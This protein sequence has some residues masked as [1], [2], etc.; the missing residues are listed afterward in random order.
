MACTVNKVL[1]EDGSSSQLF[2]ALASVMGDSLAL[3]TYLELK[4]NKDKYSKIYELNAQGEINAQNYLKT[5][6][7]KLANFDSYRQQSDVMDMLTQQFLAALKTEAQT[8][9]KSTLTGINLE[10][11]AKDISLVPRIVDQ[12]K[13]SIQDAV[14]NNPDIPAKQKTLLLSAAENFE[15]YITNREYYTDESGKDRA[16]D[17]LGPVGDRLYKHGIHIKTS[18][19]SNIDEQMEERLADSEEFDNVDTEQ[20]TVDRVRIYD[21]TI[22][23]TPPAS[24][25]LEQLK[26]YL[27]GV[28][29]VSKDYVYSEANPV[30]TFELSE[31][32]QYRGA[33]ADILYSNLSGALKGIQSVEEIGNRLK[34]AIRTN[35]QLVPIYNDLINEQAITIPR[36]G[37][38][39]PLEVALFSLAKQDYNM[40]SVVEMP[41]G[42]VVLM[43]SNSSSVRK[44]IAQ[45][46]EYNIA[47]VKKGDTTAIQERITKLLKSKPL[48]MNLN[49]KT[50]NKGVAVYTPNKS[51]L[52][53]VARAFTLAG[54]EGVTAE[55]LDT[56]IKE[57]LV[58]KELIT[59][60]VESLTPYSIITTMLR[61]LPRKAL[62]SQ[63]DIFSKKWEKGEGRSIK[64]LSEIVGQNKSDIVVGA[65]LSGKGTMTYP[66]NYGSA[67][68]DTMTLLSSQSDKGQEYLNQF[69]N[70]PMYANT[71]LMSIFSKADGGKDLANFEFRTMDTLTNSATNNG[72][73]YGDLSTF[74]ALITRMNAF[75]G[76]T[77]KEGYFQAFTPTQADRG[78]VMTMTVPTY[79]SGKN[80]KVFTKETIADEGIREWLVNQT[81]AELTRAATYVNHAKIDTY[82]DRAKEFTLFPELNGIMNMEQMQLKD[83]DRMTAEIMPRAEKA[84]FDAVQEDIQ[85]YLDNDVLIKKSE[86]L[87]KL[88]PDFKNRFGSKV[89]KLK[90]ISKAD[91]EMFLANN[92]I[93]TYESMLFLSGDP[94][95]Y[96]NNIKLNKR[97]ALPFTPGGKL[98]IGDA[99]GMKQS[100]QVKILKEAKA[101]SEFAELYAA[102]TGNKK[103]FNNTDIADGW[104]I[105]SIDR[106][107]R[108][109]L[110]RGTHT[111]AGLE[112]L[113]QL[114]SWKDGDIIEDENPIGSKKMFYFKVQQLP[115][116][117]MAPLSQKYSL[118]PA[119]PSLFEQK[120]NGEFKYPTLAEISRELRSGRADEIVMESAFK[121]GIHNVSTVDDLITSEPIS[122]END[123]VREV[124]IV[125]NKEKVEDILGSQMRKLVI[126]NFVD[127]GTLNLNGQTL[128]A[129]DALM[130]YNRALASTVSLSS[131]EVDRMLMPGGKVNY[132]NLARELINSA[133]NSSHQNTAYYTN[134][135]SEFVEGDGSMLP[136]NYPT[137]GFR[138]DNF[139][140]SSYRKSV[141][142]IKM[143]GHSA[144]QISSFGT[145]YSKKNE[146]LQ[147]GSNLKF[148]RFAKNGK[149]LKGQD[150]LDLAKKVRKF[151]KT[152]DP[153]LAEELS[154]YTTMPAEVRV[155]PAFFLKTIKNLAIQ[156]TLNNKTL[157]K[158]AREFSTKYGKSEASKKALYNSKR[159]ILIP[160]YEAA[161]YSK[162]LSII[163]HSDGTYNMDK[164]SELGLD[165]IVL[166]RIPTQGKNSMLLAKIKEFLPES[167]GNTIQ[168]P[169]EI[170]D[171]SGSDFDIDKVFIE[172]P[173]FKSSKDSATL[174]RHTYDTA[175]DQFSKDEAQSA[176]FD[177]HKS[178]L[179]SPKHTGE[180]L[181]PN[182]T[183]RLAEV[184][185]ALGI[186]EANQTGN[187]ASIKLQETFRSNNQQGKNLISIS[188]ISSVMHAVAQH[189]KPKFIAQYDIAGQTLE[190][191]RTHNIAGTELISTEIA[192]IQNAAVDNAREPLL[193]LLNINSF[194]AS[195]ALLLVSAGHG[196]KFASAVL[197]APVVKDLSKAYQKYER[198]MNQQDAYDA[199]Y[200]EIIK[201][202]K[203]PRNLGSKLYNMNSFTETTAVSLLG[204]TRELTL[205]D[206]AMSLQAFHGFKL[207]GDQLQK[208]QRIMNSDSKG[209]PAS[210]AKLFTLYTDL[211][212]IPGTKAYANEIAGGES[213][214]TNYNREIN[215]SPI[216]VDKEA[217]N[218]SYLSAMEE[219]AIGAALKANIAISP[220]AS[221]QFQNVLSKAIEK[222]GYLSENAQISI[223]S[224]Y[225]TYL[226]TNSTSNNKA[227][228]GISEAME[229]GE[230]N[231]LT[232]TSHPESTARILDMFKQAVKAGELESNDFI[233]QL[234]VIEDKGRSYVTFL[235]STARA[236][237]GDVKA[238]MMHYYEDLM[239]GTDLE[240]RL[241]K[242]LADYAIVHYG[243]STSINSFM[244]FIPPSAHRTYMNANEGM[245]IPG[246]FENL[247]QEY[248][249]TETFDNDADK[250]LD[251]YIANNSTKLG[252]KSFQSV[253]DFYEDVYQKEVTRKPLLPYVRIY[254]ANIKDYTLYASD[255]N[256]QLTEIPLRGVKNLVMEYHNGPSF[257]NDTEDLG[258]LDSTAEKGNAS[259]VNQKVMDN[260]DW[261]I[262]A[263]NDAIG[264]DLLLDKFTFKDAAAVEPYLV[265]LEKRLT[266]DKR[267]DPLEV[268][269]TMGVFI[270]A[271]SIA[272]RLH[273]LSQTR[274]SNQTYDSI[275]K[276]FI[277][278]GIDEHLEGLYS[279]IIR[280]TC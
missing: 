146:T 92:L 214:L 110:A 44:K 274:K 105:G 13:E 104:G 198:V 72:V 36:V 159:D 164:L 245:S 109:N 237:P 271:K 212:G 22:L 241:A 263:F 79:A 107:R 35:P 145:M 183:E 29:K 37:K 91:M 117:L 28:R 220:A 144:V 59:K 218:T 200:D 39:K 1:L 27:Q 190:L 238:D 195:S 113:S 275:F 240:Q 226:A 119:I 32:G 244:E 115:S 259:G 122:L 262:E 49:K 73:G 76:S 191:G 186:S 21:M 236:V 206:H 215:A 232:Q 106:F 267:I 180:L 87:Y 242:S 225:N 16:R 20:K 251:L 90:T 222:I 249:N 47:T 250:F 255:F 126:G 132:S 150:A 82:S 158:E 196:L 177:F 19:M 84:F 97:L 123:F 65:Y 154:E 141:N 182:G 148:V 217:Y 143:P 136:I 234:N 125:P 56:V 38:Y 165:E 88:N 71:R 74:D 53:E 55:A 253:E 202:Y 18:P 256:A 23:E 278:Q 46:W 85:Y 193:G 151:T 118:F 211:A 11:L 153:K 130:L 34:S 61:A 156:N 216:S 219:G 67:A 272:T 78:N 173:N 279:E 258:T 163:Q 93:Y 230:F 69:L 228:S 24:T 254:D 75:F 231:Y 111:D 134:A 30:P 129:S 26:V 170:V 95:F 100:Y 94:A 116:G 25:I 17:L 31:V 269:G 40:F 175:K 178:I 98:A 276:E 15:S 83:V 252:F 209:T 205:N 45:T 264:K 149:E 235:N 33:S 184:I 12:I 6:K 161:E 58:N 7:Y 176:I 138:L 99:T 51:A 103:A 121:T 248:N 224:T 194:T 77:A 41:T 114:E 137:L 57:G 86:N 187:L 102:I 54:F 128:S 189:I 3:E 277:Q 233:E 147:V 9:S 120:V 169:G 185:D 181:M 112:T 139:I 101:T 270:T 261:E 227:I 166:Y 265:K 81:Q 131:K 162:L 243:F 197:N 201:K 257:F 268:E 247:Q 52:S 223:L 80:A 208:F 239:H 273:R 135:L 10:G 62:L 192:E 157:F 221:L 229:R 260:I 64:L 127:G 89:G 280:R 63:Q 152:S 204:N 108:I 5:V 171:Q 48:M 50:I 168:V 179:S 199:A 14:E 155:T 2:K 203:I 68:Q 207:I 142:R 43:D 66:L 210:T 140:N 172:M 167:S 188:S 174:E 42:E 96:G 8:S 246:V 124:Q 160:K 133:N 213:L 70:D 266:E 60:G 4:S